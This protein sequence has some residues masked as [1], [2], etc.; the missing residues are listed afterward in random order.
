M[1]AAGGDPNP[2]MQTFKSSHSGA[3]WVGERDSGGRDKKKARRVTHLSSFVS[4][5]PPSAEG[6]C[7]K[8]EPEHRKTQQS[9]SADSSSCSSLLPPFVL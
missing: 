4:S 9:R 8:E 3:Q 7:E 6:K 1:T 5:Q 2:G